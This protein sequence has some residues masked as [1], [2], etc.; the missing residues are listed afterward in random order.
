MNPPP[1]ND[2]ELLFSSLKPMDRAKGQPNL[3]AKKM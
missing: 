2:D 3:G 1:G